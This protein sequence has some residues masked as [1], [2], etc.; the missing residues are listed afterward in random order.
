MRD[1]GIVEVGAA[2]RAEHPKWCH[3]KDATQPSKSS[4]A[5]TVFSL[6]SGVAA[7]ILVPLSVLNARQDGED[8][9]P[10]FM[11]I[12]ALAC[13]GVQVTIMVAARGARDVTE[14]RKA[15]LVSAAGPIL[16]SAGLAIGYA[17]QQYW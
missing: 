6:V 3:M 9:L 16:T 1:A 14:S 10:V 8:W 2:E 7:F 4:S 17:I 15:V 11:F 5:K 12:L 13:L